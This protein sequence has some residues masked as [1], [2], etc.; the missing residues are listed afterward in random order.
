[1]GEFAEEIKQRYI[2]LRKS[3]LSFSSIIN[4]FEKFIEIYGE[5]IYMQDLICYPKI[6]AVTF[7]NINY[8]RMFVKERLEIV[9]NYILGGPL[10]G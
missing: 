5:D 4:E 7:N 10:N 2:E 8:L 6:P 1:M 9:D 3:V